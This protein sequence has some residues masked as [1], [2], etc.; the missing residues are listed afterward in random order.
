MA[1]KQ[2]VCG[3]EV[4]HAKGLCKPCFDFFRKQAKTNLAPPEIADELRAKVEAAGSLVPRED[5]RF[6]PVPASASGAARQLAEEIQPSVKVFDAVPKEL[7]FNTA[8]PV[9]AQHVAGAVAKSLHDFRAAA[10]ILRPDLSPADQAGLAYQLERDPHVGA[11][12]QAELAKLG[13]TDEAKQKYFA[14][15]WSAATDFRPQAE[16]DRLNA[17]RLLGRAFL[18]SD[19]PS[20]KTEAPATLP[21]VGLDAGLDKMGLSDAVVASVPPTQLSN[22]EVDEDTRDEMETNLQGE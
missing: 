11:A 2:T 17:M 13:L 20:G 19:N 10:K 21:I 9:V 3:H 18:P 6:R 8:D 12:L 22:F 15:L 1:R 14:L 7:P 4:H 16:R 5:K